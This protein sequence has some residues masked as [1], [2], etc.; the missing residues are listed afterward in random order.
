MSKP[1]AADT[2]WDNVKQIFFAIILA[3]LIKTSIVEAY[4]IPS[5]SME[6]TLLIGDFLVAN[7]FVYG[8]RLPLA[9]RVIR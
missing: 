7:K 4:K 8:A 6:D 3:V 1:S 9:F 5:A 2:F